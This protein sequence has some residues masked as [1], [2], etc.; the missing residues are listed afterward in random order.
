VIV[1]YFPMIAAP[2]ALPATLRHG[3]WPHGFEWLALG[4]V[5]LFAQLGQVWITR[6]LGLVP[7][8]RAT[9]ISYA[10]IVFA[11]FFGFALFGEVP[12]PP[13]L[14]GTALIVLG[15]SLSARAAA[16]APVASVEP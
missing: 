13:T 3:I 2:A 7:A 16:A 8:G 9:T 5:A 11:A 12:G 14:A 6:G 15:T 4:G 10:Q 1:L